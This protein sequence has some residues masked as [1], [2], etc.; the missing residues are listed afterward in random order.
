MSKP[1]A[2]TFQSRDIELAVQ[3][4]ICHICIFCSYLDGPVECTWRITRIPLN[5]TSEDT[6]IFTKLGLLGVRATL[7]FQDC[8]VHIYEQSY[9]KSPGSP[10]LA[11]KR[12]K[13]KIKIIQ[14]KSKEQH[15][16]Y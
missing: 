13:L 5:N 10:A 1:M 6:F 7:A 3:S 8:L 2:S 14:T 12:P 11:Q 9:S 15:K 4:T 16:K